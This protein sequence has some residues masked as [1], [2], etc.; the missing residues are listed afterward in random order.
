MK[1]NNGHPLCHWQLVLFCFQASVPSITTAVLSS[2]CAFLFCPG[3]SGG[4]KPC[5]SLGRYQSPSWVVNLGSGRSRDWGRKTVL[6]YQVS[7]YSTDWAKSETA[8]LASQFS[9][10]GYT[11]H[12]INASSIKLYPENA[13]EMMGQG[14]LI[15]IVKGLCFLLTRWLCS[16]FVHFSGSEKEWSSTRKAERLSCMGQCTAKGGGVISND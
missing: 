9:Q 4:V 16:A 11:Q 1:I 14:S 6:G 5:K 13:W 10:L 12:S 15:A 8:W 7:S 3:L 2:L